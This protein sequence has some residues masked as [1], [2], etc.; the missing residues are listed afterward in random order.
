MNSHCFYNCVT[1]YQVVVDLVFQDHDPVNY[2][3][4]RALFVFLSLVLISIVTALMGAK[5]LF[6]SPVILIYA[7]KGRIELS[8]R[9]KQKMGRAAPF[10]L[11]TRLIVGPLM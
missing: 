2:W 9:T 7:D 8:D 5:H 4:V 3:R 6:R 11:L 1:G 10:C